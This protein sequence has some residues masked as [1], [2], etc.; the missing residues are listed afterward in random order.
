MADAK[1]KLEMNGEAR[2][3][4]YAQGEE[5]MRLAHVA[6]TGQAH[7]YWF[8]DESKGGVKSFPKASEKI[9]NGQAYFSDF[10]K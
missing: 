6:I 8:L 9:D 4:D 1:A 7:C 2:A 3:Y 5:V 10:R